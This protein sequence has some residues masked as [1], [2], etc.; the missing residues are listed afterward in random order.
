MW[1]TIGFL[2]GNCSKSKKT[3]KW[4]KEEFEKEMMKNP[5]FAKNYPRIMKEYNEMMSENNKSK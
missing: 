1:F 2:K 3:K 4:F 5:T